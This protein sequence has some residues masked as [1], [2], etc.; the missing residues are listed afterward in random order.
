MELGVDLVR[1]SMKGSPSV[2][3]SSNGEFYGWIYGIEVLLMFVDL[4]FPGATMDIINIPE[5]PFD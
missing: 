4:I 1:V 2:P 3:G 5:P